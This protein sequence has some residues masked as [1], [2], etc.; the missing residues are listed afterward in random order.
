MKKYLFIG[1]SIV[2]V[3]VLLLASLSNVVGFQMV[4]ST[5]QTIINNE[6]NPKELLFQTILDFA[7]NKEIQNIIRKTQM[8]TERVFTLDAR[9]SILNTPVLTKN[10]LK[11]SYIVGLMLFKIINKSTIHSMAKHYQLSNSGLHNEI[12]ATIEKD[13]R[14]NAEM[15]QLSN[16]KCDCENHNTTDLY[17]PI[18]CQILAYLFLF[19][20]IFPNITFPIWGSA[21]LIAILLN[22]T[23][24]QP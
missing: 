7:N 24:T 8:G 14:L 11:L 1:G 19:I 17:T 10:Q 13:A 12:S 18:L 20:G 15:T 6:T 23:W 3:V 2:A 22:C 16:S 5:N 4:R 9:I 21:L